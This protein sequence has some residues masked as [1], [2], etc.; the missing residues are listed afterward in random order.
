MAADPYPPSSPSPD[1]AAVPPPLSSP[2]YGAGTDPSTGTTGLTPNIAAGLACLL[3]PISSIIFLVLEKRNPFVRFWAMQATIFGAAW[4]LLAVLMKIVGTV[5]AFIPL[6][7]WII[8]ALLF[9]AYLLLTIAGFIVWIITL[10][11]S[12]S[13]LEW[14]IP[15]LGRLA[16]QQLTKMNV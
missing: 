1:P 4:F 3:P 7:G 8:V 10:I 15:F 2:S 11:K 14:D 16:R 9:F 13:G 12:F 6:L 5:F